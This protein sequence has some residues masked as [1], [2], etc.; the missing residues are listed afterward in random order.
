VRYRVVVTTPAFRRAR[1]AENKAQRAGAL[2]EAA[3]SLALESGVTSVTLTAVA[4]R[5]GV[6]HSAVRRY[7]SSHKGV[8]LRLAGEGWTRWSRGVGDALRARPS[9]V[10]AATLAEVLVRELSADPLFCD[11]LANVPLHLEHDVDPEHV[12]AFKRVSH[13]AVMSVAAAITDAQPELGPAAALDVVTATVALAATLW[14]VAHPPEALALA[15]AEE[16][17]IA[18]T[19]D[20]EFGPTATRLLT[21]TCTG[22]LAGRTALRAAGAADRSAR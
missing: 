14:Q 20:L 6:H 9:P 21:A 16:P 18:D 7:F 13:A 17:E 3:R 12:L 5:A 1:S 11:L 19:W 22:L 15:Y 10:G 4:H 8:L 2:V